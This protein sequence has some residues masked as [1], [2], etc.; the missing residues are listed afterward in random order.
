VGPWLVEAAEP[1]RPLAVSCLCNVPLAQWQRD[2]LSAVRRDL[3][4]GEISDDEALKRLERSPSWGWTVM[5]PP[6]Q[7]V[8]VV[9]GG[10][11]T[12][13]LAPRVGHQGTGGLAPGG[14]P[15]LVPDGFKEAPTAR[16]GQCGHWLPP[17]AR[18]DQGPGPKPRGLPRPARR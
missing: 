14:L 17:E 15:L 6:S 9:A 12:R 18:Q 10:C 8:G 16:R 7:W 5:A 13:A 1:R 4:A 3:K 2:A 11:R